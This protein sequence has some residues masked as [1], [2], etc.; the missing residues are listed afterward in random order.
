MWKEFGFSGGFV[1]FFG[2]GWW[3]V[4]KFSILIHVIFDSEFNDF[5]ILFSEMLITNTSVNKALTSQSYQTCLRKHSQSTVM[6]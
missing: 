1:W 5:T 3:F 4:F 6:Q 2:G